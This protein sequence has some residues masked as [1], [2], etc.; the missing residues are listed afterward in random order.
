MSAKERNAKR[1]RVPSRKVLEMEEFK[2][3]RK[4]SRSAENQP[5]ARDAAESKANKIP[6][7]VTGV[8]K[9]N[10]K[11][12][13]VFQEEPAR[14]NRVDSNNNATLLK[15]QTKT[16]NSKNSKVTIKESKPSTS[17]AGRSNSKSPLKPS[18]HAVFDDIQMEV[19]GV[20]ELDYDE[21]ID[22]DGEWLD[23]E[24]EV[25][26]FEQQE[27]EKVVTPVPAIGENNA[28][29]PMVQLPMDGVELLEDAPPQL[30]RWFERMFAQQ[31]KKHAEETPTGKQNN[32]KGKQKVSDNLKGNR[33]EDNVIKSPS[34]TTIYAPALNRSSGGY[35]PLNNQN[36]GFK[37]NQPEPSGSDGKNNFS[38]EEINTIISNFVE[39]VRVEQVVA[40]DNEVRLQAQQGECR[41]AS[42]IQEAI[43]G[44]T[45]ARRRTDNAVVEAEK[46]RAAIA[47]VPGESFTPFD[48]V[49]NSGMPAVIPN[50]GEGISDDD[51]FHLTCHIEPSLIHR[52]E[53][54]EFVELEKLL[55]KDKYG[56]NGDE[57]RLEWVHRDGGTFLVPAQRDNKITNFRRWEQAFRA[58]A[59]IYY[60]ANPQRLKE[61]WQYITI[62]NTAA[63]AYTWDNVY[64][65]DV[66]FRHLMAFNPNRSWAITY[67]QRWN[68][69]MREPL[70]KKPR[71]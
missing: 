36:K 58:Y 38:N 26:P 35:S 68:L 4:R 52:I 5:L 6:K 28:K 48:R 44:Q 25:E 67:N 11:R 3:S 63:S 15:L 43:P 55:P 29:Q 51:F 10:A 54:G 65:Y 64:N 16:K 24:V 22:S 1:V 30:Q 7:K 56:K 33:K 14:D 42:S 70:P 32:Q 39:S 2:K 37:L 34:D 57:N 23:K 49:G 46:F 17:G 50:I 69:S 20:E 9:S 45:E 61:I 66:T 53:K 41:R 18:N 71:F 62:I 40:P 12:K 59:T 19:E 21:E 31:M 8:A 60:G 47:Q 13:I 27:S